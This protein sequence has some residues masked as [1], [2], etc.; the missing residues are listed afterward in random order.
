MFQLGMVNKYGL[1][2][3][4]QIGL[5]KI[6][7]NEKINQ[8]HILKLVGY[9]FECHMCLCNIQYMV[10][11]ITMQKANKSLL[12]WASLRDYCCLN[13]IL[14]CHF[15]YCPSNHTSLYKMS[16]HYILSQNTAQYCLDFFLQPF[17]GVSAISFSFP[18]YWSCQLLDFST[19]H[20]V[21]KSRPIVQVLKWI[22]GWLFLLIQMLSTVLIWHELTKKQIWWKKS[23]M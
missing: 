5:P 4:N 22:L 19:V 15:R 20:K 10:T 18:S 12:W 11:P 8:L 17:L 16:N 9:S 6:W 21:F 3:V 1:I 7:N 13:S 2:H 23:K 14:D